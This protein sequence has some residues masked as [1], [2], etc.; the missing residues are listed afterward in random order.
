MKYEKDLIFKLL[1]LKKYRFDIEKYKINNALRKFYNQKISENGRT[2]KTYYEIID[3]IGQNDIDKDRFYY[4]YWE[5]GECLYNAEKYSEA[6]KYFKIA[7][8]NVI[9]ENYKKNKFKF[10]S[11]HYS[12][13][14]ERY[15][16][17][18]KCFIKAKE[19]DN[20]DYYYNL[21]MYSKNY[22]KYSNME[23]GDLYASFKAKNQAI[24]YYEKEIHEIDKVAIYRQYDYDPYVDGYLED[25]YKRKV[26][27]KEDKINNIYRII[28]SL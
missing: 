7:I 11:N 24:K 12:M 10:K 19:F 28:D 6:S 27:E 21:N 20:A 13:F 5:M 16:L 26:K 4:I 14:L 3:Y 23:M 25:E 9:S 15:C 22:P 2:L 17:S 18:V 8:D 1:I